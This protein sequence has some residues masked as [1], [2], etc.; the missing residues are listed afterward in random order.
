M[1]TKI[2]HLLIASAVLFTGCSD[3]MEGG[4]DGPVL[5][6]VENNAANTNYQPAFPGQTRANGVR[7]STPFVSE[8]LTSS[9]SSPC[10]ITALPDGRLLITEKA[11]TMR[12][13]STTGTLSNAITGIPA[14]NSGGQGGL[15]GLCVDP[16]FASNRMVYWVFSEN[17]SGGNLTSVAKGRLSDSET[18]I[19]N[20]VVIYRAT[21][22]ANVG[23]LHYGGRI[24]FDSTGNL[25]VSTGERSDLST[26]PLAQSVTAAVGKILRITT[27]GQPAPG[28]PA[29]T[30]SGALPVLY[31]IGHRNPQGMAIHPQTGELWQ[32]EHGPRG[33][34]EIN[35][36]QGGANYGW[37]TITYGIEY[38][39]AVIGDG[40][41]QKQ[42]MEQPVYYWDPVI[43]PSGMTFYRGNAMPEWQNN[44]FIASLS[45]MHIARLVIENN[46]VVGEERLL[47]GENQRFRD[48][49]QGKDNALYA[50]TDGGKLYRIR[51]Q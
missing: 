1:N 21:P 18:M 13:M 44:L 30:Q 51:K 31:S 6:P 19:E 50:V 48:I 7:T 46:R 49:T 26:R 32:S 17:V 9:L 34:D 33:G 12:I 14:V 3:T 35:R 15:L 23:N 41:Q 11:G 42:G 36:V 40:I 22:S 4:E 28:N 37:P 5:P 25:F 24:L 43:S 39:G 20:P 45:G 47:T 16:Q 2:Y 8:V 38:S 10:G 29:F 27:T